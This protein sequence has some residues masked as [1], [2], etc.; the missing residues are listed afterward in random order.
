M[1]IPDRIEVPAAT[2]WPIVLAFGLTLVFAGFVTA[3]SVS[4]L[5]AI[6]AVVGAVG[7]FRE[8]LPVESH[9]WAPVVG[10]E[11]A[12]QT[13]REAVE[14]IAGV[15]AVP[16]AWLPV[17]IYPISAGIKGG[18]A[19]GAVM[20]LLAALYGILSGNGI[21]YAMNLL[22]GGLFPSMATE[23]SSQIGDFHIYRFLV[24]VPIHLL[25][26][27]LVGLLYGAMLPMLPRRPILLGG[28]VTPLL[29]SGLIYGGLAFINPVMNQHIDWVWFVASQ[30]GFG[31]VAG[32]VVAVQERIPTRQ[33]APL[34]VR[35][36]IEAPGLVPEHQE[37]LKR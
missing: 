14:R 32:V 15:R 5:G 3:V 21:W 10:E 7:W 9:E 13:S 33:R 6:L 30:I 18:L 11:I 29:W 23:T 20:A 4:I 1:N 2:A 35:M 25:I 17:E 12:I 16:R 34:S 27:L 22:V 24:A 28:F 37:D 31:I 26:S 19:G 36:G 8:V